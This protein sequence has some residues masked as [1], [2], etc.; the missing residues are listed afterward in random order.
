MLAFIASL[1]VKTLAFAPTLAEEI[2]SNLTSQKSGAILGTHLK[3]HTSPFFDCCLSCMFLSLSLFI[4]RGII[5]YNY[6]NIMIDLNKFT[7]NHAILT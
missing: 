5:R 6:K 2:A 3:I 4:Y 7:K 1:A